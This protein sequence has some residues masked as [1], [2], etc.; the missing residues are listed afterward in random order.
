MPS[1]MHNASLSDASWKIP[2]LSINRILSSNTAPGMIPALSQAESLAN[3]LR[4][5]YLT[6]QNASPVLAALAVYRRSLLPPATST[7]TA[8]KSQDNTP[9][10]Q[11]KSSKGY[12]WSRWW[13]RGESAGIPLDKD[14][15]PAPPAQGTATQPAESKGN[16]NSS[17]KVRAL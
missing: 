15:T 17:T 2:V 16:V 1:L 11:T 9:A 12:A 3:I 14:S 10:A 5:S 8:Q 7:L 4:S 6:W 13:R